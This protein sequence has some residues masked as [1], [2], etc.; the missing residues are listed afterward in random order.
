MNKSTEKAIIAAGFRVYGSYVMVNGELFPLPLVKGNSKLGRAVWHS[1]TAP[2]NEELTVLD[3]KTGEIIATCKGTCP[4]TCKG[5]YGKTGHYQHDN[6]KLSVIMRTRLLREYPAIYFLLVRTQLTYENIKYLRIHAVGDFIPGEARGFYEILKDFP[7]V[8]AWT[9]TKVPTNEE[10]ELLDSL[11]NMNIVKSVIPG[12]GF[13]FGHVAYIANLYYAL[14][15]AGESVYICRCGIDP[16]QHC[17]DC[18]GCSS[19]K[20]VLFIEHS[21]KYNAKKDYGFSKL[22]KLIEQQPRAIAGRNA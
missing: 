2:T 15:R 16:E 11:P 5:C 22:K 6:V 14:K 21:T 12:Y 4:L 3:K 7:N 17:S 1:S 19:H 20:Y 18:T 8:K 9:Y 13:N 10:I